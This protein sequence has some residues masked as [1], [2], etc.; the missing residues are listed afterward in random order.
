MSSKVTINRLATGVPGLDEVLGGGLPEFSF[1]LIAGPP[2]CGKTTLAHQMMF[3]LATPQRPALFFTVL[4]E[5]P[6]K[7]LRYQ[8]QFDFFDSAA[9]NQ[10]IHY[11]NLAD[12]TQAGDLDEVL[13]RIVSEVQAHSPGLVFVDSFRSVVL[14]SQTRDNPNNN[15]PLFV[16][17]LG[18]L[19]TTWQATTF[20]I[21]EYFNETDTNPVFTVADGLIWLRQSV[22]RN[23]MVR[24]MEI[25]KMRGQPTLPGLHTFRIATSGVRVFA[26]AAISTVETPLEFP[27]KRLKMGVAR[28]DDMLGGGLPQGYSLLVAGPSGS[29]KSILAATFLAEGARNGET[30][31]IAVFE[32]RPNHSQNPTLAAL[33]HSGQVGLV[34]SRAAD[35]SIDEIVHL[36]LTE[37]TRIKATR[38]VVDSLSG[39]ELALAPTFREDFRESLARMV[40]ALTGAGITVL[41]TS[42]L[43]DRY[44]DLRFSPYGTAFL[45]DAIIVQRYIEVQSRLQRIM[46]VVKVRASAHSDELRLYHIDDDGLQIGEMLPD[47]EGLLGGRPTRQHVDKGEV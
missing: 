34:D 3:A 33:I 20:L 14:A 24:K 18:M 5:P 30:G 19:M 23:S 26:P 8:Q 42:E 35:L 22:Q 43:E 9:I 37:I 16:Q 32:Q 45:T 7:M 12:D 47:Q 36:L 28:L 25:M 29:G 44:T 39:F 38:V 10:S 21:G 40:S 2:G 27:I 17:Q 6:L 13:R 31:V 4:G 46:A 1:N 11:I 15:L 41:L